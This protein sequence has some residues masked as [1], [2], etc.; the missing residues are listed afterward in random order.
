[1]FDSEKNFRTCLTSFPTEK[2]AQSSKY[3]KQYRD[4][5]C[6]VEIIFS[7]FLRLYQIADDG[8]PLPKPQL[9]AGPATIDA[10]LTCRLAGG[11]S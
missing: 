2:P 6:K 9:R 8:S 4:F 5:K 11:N 7:Q 10:A 1:M 3:R